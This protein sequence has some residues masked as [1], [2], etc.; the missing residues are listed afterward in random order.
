MSEAIFGGPHAIF[1]AVPGCRFARPDY[2]LLSG[3]DDIGVGKII[4]L[5]QKAGAV[6]LGAGIGQAIA[7]IQAGLAV[8]LAAPLAET[9]ERGDRDVRD[10]FGDRHY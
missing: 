6:R 5:E 1:A 4:A 9:L 3:S 2:K 10:L 8:S 7:E